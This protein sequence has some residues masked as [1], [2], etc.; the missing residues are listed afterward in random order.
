MFVKAV[1][2]LNE[3]APEALSQIEEIVFLGEETE[4][5]SLIWIREQL[6]PLSAKVI[7]LGHHDNVGANNYLAKVAGD[8]LAVIA[9]MYENLTYAGIEASMIPGLNLLCTNGGGTPEIFRGKGEKQLFDPTIQGLAAKMLERLKAPLTPEQLISYDYKA[10]NDRWMEFHRRVCEQIHTPETVTAQPSIARATLEKSEGYTNRNTNSDAPAGRGHSVDVCIP[11]YN[12]RK[13]FEQTLWSLENQTTSDFSVIAVD[14]GSTDPSSIELFESMA[15]KYASRGWTFFR[16]DNRFVDAAR[17]AAVR[18]S[19]AEYLFMLDA[20]DAISPNAIERLLEAS[21]LSGDDCL[22]TGSCWFKGDEYPQDAKTGQVTAPVEER[23][24]PVGPNLSAAL[25]DPWSLGG[26]A[27]FIRRAVFEAIGGYRELHGVNHE[28]WELQ[29]RL[30]FAGYRI[31]VVP[32]F[33]YLY[34]RTQDSLSTGADNYRASRRLIDTYNKQ[35]ATIGVHNGGDMMFRL[36]KRCEELEIRLNNLTLQSLASAN[37][38]LERSSSSAQEE[39]SGF[40]DELHRRFGPDDKG[41]LLIRHLRRIYRK[42]FSL[43]TRLELH[44]KLMELIGRR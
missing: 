30:A 41:P 16:Q 39:R 18:R 15:Q 4:P 40:N 38:S 26:S 7:H 43:H 27:I 24:I 29:L 33:L 37:N 5:G 19:Q 42:Q 14:D 22:V 25:F 32:E 9:S 17:N 20:D 1:L 31:D 8:T 34:R 21:R 11:F 44:G 3:I 35:L 12:K 2:R 10:A 23:L 13:Y 28:D 6:K 36:Q